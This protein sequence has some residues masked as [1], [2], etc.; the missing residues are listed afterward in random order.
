MEDIL[1]LILSTVLALL[2]MGYKFRESGKEKLMHM[3]SDGLTDD[4]IISI[5]GEKQFNY[6][7]NL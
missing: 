4:E 1:I 7:N 5:I 6:L 3:R 2:F